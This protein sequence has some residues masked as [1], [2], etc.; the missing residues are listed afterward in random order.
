MGEANEMIFILPKAV[1]RYA[2]QDRQTVLKSSV[3]YGNTDSCVML[4]RR[5]HSIKT[6]STTTANN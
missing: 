2:P 3:M 1:K 6:A 4:Q 5:T